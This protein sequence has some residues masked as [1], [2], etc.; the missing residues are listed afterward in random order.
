MCDITFLWEKKIK[1]RWEK[2]VTFLCKEWGFLLKKLFGLHLGTGDYG[3][4]VVDR[5]AMLLQQFRSFYKYSG[6]GFE[7]SHKLHRVLY[8]HATNH[9]SSGPGQS[10]KLNQIFKEHIYTVYMIT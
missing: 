7:S 9:D 6:Q 1:C 4:L 2:S 5:S 8:S 3:H 10:Y